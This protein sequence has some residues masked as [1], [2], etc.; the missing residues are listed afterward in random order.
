MMTTIVRTRMAHM[1]QSNRILIRGIIEAGG[2]GMRREKGLIETTGHP[3][4]LG[5]ACP[6]EI[7]LQP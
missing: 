2:I 7:C 5:E 4:T 3:D 6:S 1:K